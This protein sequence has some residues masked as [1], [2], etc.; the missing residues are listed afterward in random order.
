MENKNNNSNFNEE[1]DFENFKTLLIKPIELIEFENL[2]ENKLIFEDD[3]RDMR[4]ENNILYNQICQ[5]ENLEF[6]CNQETRE[7]LL[8]RQEKIIIDEL[9]NVVGIDEMP[10][11]EDSQ[12]ENEAEK[13]RNE[14][15]ISNKY[16]PINFF[17]ENMSNLNNYNNE[18]LVQD[19]NITMILKISHSMEQD[20][21]EA[22]NINYLR[23]ERAKLEASDEIY[24]KEND[25]NIQDL[26]KENY[27]DLNKQ[28]SS[29]INHKNF[30]DRS[31]ESNL[32]EN[33]KNG[34]NILHANKAHNNNFIDTSSPNKAILNKDFREDGIG[35]QHYIYLYIIYLQLFFTNCFLLFISSH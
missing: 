1:E 16:T 12:E 22:N 6:I 29:H 28:N 33:E 34:F 4:K 11:L 35:Q 9:L 32:N 21:E 15:I 23:N 25:K 2:S 24:K 31:L 7:S 26:N 10:P 13:I 20:E 5:A 18:N 30:L 27:R 14:L 17:D 8:E 19:H 3:F